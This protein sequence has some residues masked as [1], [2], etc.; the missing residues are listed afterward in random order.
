MNSAP[1]GD[2]GMRIGLITDSPAISQEVR[3]ALK[4]SD[5]FQLI[6][7]AK[8]ESEVFQKIQ[9]DQPDILMLKL[10]AA[11]MGGGKLIRALMEQSLPGV[12]LLDTAGGSGEVFAALGAG[13]MDVVPFSPALSPETRSRN[14]RKKLGI[15]ARLRNRSRHAPRLPAVPRLVVIGASTGGPHALALLLAGLPAD[16]NAAVLVAQHL[17]SSFAFALA[18]WLNAQVPLLV[19]VAAEGERPQAGIVYLA[20]TDDHLVITPRLSFAYT[21]EPAAIP[22]RPSVDVLFESVHQHWPRNSRSFPGVAVLL[23][24]MGRDGARGLALLCQDGWR[25]IAQ[26]EKSS[27]IYGMPKAARELNAASRIL[28]LEAIAPAILRFLNPAAPAPDPA[29]G[30]GAADK[31][32]SLK[33]GDDFPA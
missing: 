4:A 9:A 26:D 33:D 21:P 22:Y 30:A 19:R 13:A 8:K 14:L 23:T 16:L 25:T 32:V 1:S 7:I 11:P 17:E 28:A 27:V 20:G 24:G 12:L 5:E 31:A 18:Q 29:R 3:F 10:P 6:W 15:V 2:K